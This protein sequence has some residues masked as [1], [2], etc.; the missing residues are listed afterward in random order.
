MEILNS[1]LTWVM[2]KRIHQMELFMKYPHEVQDELIKK[3]I[4]QARHTEFGKQ[5]D[6]ENIRSLDQFKSNLPISTYEDFFPYIKD[7]K[8]VV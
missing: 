5:Y 8:S 2:K 7:R 4:Y 6:F 3:L 1:I